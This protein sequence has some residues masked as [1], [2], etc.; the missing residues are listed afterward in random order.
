MSM[1]CRPYVAFAIL[2]LALT[3]LSGAQ[4][5]SAPTPQG[6]G[7]SARLPGAEVPST[8]PGYVPSKDP[9]DFTGVWRDQPLPGSVMFH[10]VPHV[11]FTAAAQADVKRRA[12]LLARVKGTSIATPH[13]M[14]R[15]VGIS[16]VITPL[17]P[18]YIL[19]SDREMVFIVTD[20]IRGVHHIYLNQQHPKHIVPSYDGDSVGHWEGNTLVIDTIGFNGRGEFEGTVHS[21]QMH[22]VQRISKSAD[23][24]SL[25]IESTLDDPKIL[26]HPVTVTKRWVWLAGQQPLEFDC[27]ENPREDN[28]AGIVF[29]DEYL[30]PV[31]IQYEGKGSEP[32]K[33]VC[34]AG[35][36]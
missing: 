28:F 31:C 24:K 6:N 18:T 30:R 29:A 27:E 7:A 1:Q 19:Q 2:G 36:K 16:N 17:T 33:V 21:D 10:L 32:S 9:Q 26:A 12:E 20:E 11:D 13:V 8:I 25:T 34:D 23:G 22:L 5:P 4:Q 15:P 14:C 35:R 3:T